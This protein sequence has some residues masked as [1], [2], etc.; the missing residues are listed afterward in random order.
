MLQKQF[1]VLH[2][3][4]FECARETHKHTHTRRHVK[5]KHK[6]KHNLRADN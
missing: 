6:H 2:N 3:L 4:T 5:H 1:M